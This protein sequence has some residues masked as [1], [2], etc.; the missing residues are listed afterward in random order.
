M[1]AQKIVQETLGA[2]QAAQR[3]EVERRAADAEEA[4]RQAAMPAGEDAANTASARALADAR[5]RGMKNVQ[6]TVGAPNGPVIR[7]TKQILE[8]ILPPGN[9]PS[10]ATIFDAVTNV[11]KKECHNLEKGE[12]SHQI[13][14][15]RR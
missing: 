3:A 10:R 6:K 9:I 4:A 7:F 15:M 11:A 2:I 8:L 14:P 12:L 5:K 13:P 1:M